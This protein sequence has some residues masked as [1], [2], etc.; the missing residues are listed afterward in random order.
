MFLNHSFLEA[1]A[2]CRS[3]AFQSVRM[4]RRNSDSEAGYQGTSDT[5]LKAKRTDGRSDKDPRL[6]HR[7]MMTMSGTLTRLSYDLRMHPVDQVK[8]KGEITKSFAKT[9]FNFG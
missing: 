4:A 3:A 9:K 6:Q 5:S 7:R 2:R 1:R 8:D